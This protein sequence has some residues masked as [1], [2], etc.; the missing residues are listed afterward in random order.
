MIKNV[1]LEIRKITLQVY[2]CLFETA[3]F[4]SARP[5]NFDTKINYSYFKTQLIQTYFPKERKISRNG[6]EGRVRGEDLLILIFFSFVFILNY[7]F[8][9]S[10]IFVLRH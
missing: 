5:Y 8:N 9:F 7:S 10:K 4:L 1:F 6:N 3:Y 2:V